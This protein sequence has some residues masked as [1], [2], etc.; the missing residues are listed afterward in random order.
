MEPSSVPIS[1]KKIDRGFRPGSLSTAYDYIDKDNFDFYIMHPLEISAFFAAF[2]VSL[3]STPITIKLAN[4][5]KL[6]DDPKN[7]PHPA[8]IQNR[9]IPRAGGLPIYL[10]VVSAILLF[11]PFD[12]HI[13]GIILGL[14]VLVA[15]GL[16]DDYK[17]NF[18]PFPRLLLQFAAAGIVVASGVGITF[19]TNP[20]GG[21]L[22]LD[23]IVI[24]VYFWGSHTI[25]LIADIFAFF[26]IVWMMNMVNWSKGVDGQ[27]PGI[28]IVAGL[29]IG[30]VSHNLFAAGDPN[31]LAITQMALI[32]SGAALGF[33]LYN[34][35]PAKILPGQGA[36]TI[37]GFMIAT[38]TILSS[39]KLAT[40]LLILLVPTIDFFYTFFRRVL[41]GRSPFFGDQKH[42]HHLLLK[43]GW[44]HRQISLFYIITCAILG[45]ISTTLSSKG[46]IFTLLGIGVVIFGVILWLHLFKK[47]AEA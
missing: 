35:H 24:P 42:L 20:L 45:L 8:H 38:L 6:L 3:L 22:R 12:K 1:H 25:V 41:A 26:W 32:T 43:S 13:L 46:K 9:V 30:L 27:M 40:A 33:L 7:R 14:T 21:I 36:S 23:Q 18:S 28:I 39:A 11:V 44:S 19:V 17:K 2:L 16:V 29:V 10:G 5:F 31:Q 34:W 15:V 4:K 37:L 47:T